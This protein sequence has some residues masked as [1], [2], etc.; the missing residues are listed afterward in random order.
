VLAQFEW[1]LTSQTIQP[2]QFRS[3]WL[4]RS[5]R[6]RAQ[7]QQMQAADEIHHGRLDYGDDALSVALLLLRRTPGQK[8]K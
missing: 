4:R 1:A 7:K 2:K 3:L 5:H 8:S 6:P